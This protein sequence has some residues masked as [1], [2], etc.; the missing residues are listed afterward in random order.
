MGIFDLII[1]SFYFIL[2]MSGIVLLIFSMFKPTSRRL[3]IG[4]IANIIIFAFFGL[5]LGMWIYQI[6]SIILL[7]LLLYVIFEKHI[8]HNKL[9]FSLWPFMLVCTGLYIWSLFIDFIILPLQ[10]FN[11]LNFNLSTALINTLGWNVF[12]LYILFIAIVSTVICYIPKIHKTIKIV[13]PIII[14]LFSIYYGIINRATFASLVL[15]NS[16][17]AGRLLGQGMNM[18]NELTDGTLNAITNEV[19]Y[20]GW[21]AISLIIFM[22]IF[23]IFII[24]D[25]TVKRPLLTLDNKKEVINHVVEN[26]KENITS[27][28]MSVS[29]A[30]EIKKYKQL[31][32]DRIISAEQFESTKNKLLEKL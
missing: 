10:V 14:I 30:D 8:N 27:Q 4:A 23:I 12:Y 13:P 6:F 2:F 21:G 19:V 3:R 11:L 24:F 28:M 7:F 16:N 25:N 15:E 31:L 18:I 20:I 22:L 1:L 17:E 26:S 32:D 5:F 29:A 9:T